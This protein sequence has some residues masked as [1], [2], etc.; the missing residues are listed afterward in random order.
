MAEHSGWPGAYLATRLGATGVA[1]E[2]RGTALQHAYVCLSKSFVV[3]GRAERGGPLI[4]LCP[5]PHRVDT[6]RR[7]GRA[8]L[9]RAAF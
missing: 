9:E 8:P 5:E 3:P 1:G 4:A 7:R 2:L 6:S